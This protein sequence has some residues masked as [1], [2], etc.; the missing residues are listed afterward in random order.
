MGIKWFKP[1]W[2]EK[3]NTSKPSVKQV[4]IIAKSPSITGGL[5]LGKM[6]T[7]KNCQ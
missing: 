3:V 4:R 6:S 1:K 5:S 7:T 2:W